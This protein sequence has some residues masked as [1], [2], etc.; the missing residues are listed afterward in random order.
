[1][2]ACALGEALASAARQEVVAPYLADVAED[3]SL[4]HLRERVRASGPTITATSP[5]SPATAGCAA[6]T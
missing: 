5:P 2:V 4:A 6:W 1:M 3:G